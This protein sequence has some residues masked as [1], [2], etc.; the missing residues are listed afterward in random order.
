MATVAEDRPQ[1]RNQDKIVLAACA[2]GQIPASIIKR[3]VA[4]ESPFRVYREHRGMT[5]AQLA[6]A[7]GICHQQIDGLEQGGSLPAA[8]TAV[9]LAGAL[10]ISIDKLM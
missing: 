8:G 9:L 2:D 1:S 10:S 6:E 5:Q 3:L 4:G 7:S